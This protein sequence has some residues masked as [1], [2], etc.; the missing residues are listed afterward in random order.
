MKPQPRRSLVAVRAEEA[1]VGGN[2]LFSGQFMGVL[3]QSL[4]RQGPD[5]LTTSR[6]PPPEEREHATVEV[7]THALAQTKQTLHALTMMR[8]LVEKQIKAQEKQVDRMEF[9]LNKSR[10][11]AAYL[12]VMKEMMHES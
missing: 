6:G 7:L 12:N 3:Q 11:D 5:A 2:P 4:A 8:D 10:N 1:N 9:A